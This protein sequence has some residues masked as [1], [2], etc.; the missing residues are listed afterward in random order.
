MGKIIMEGAKEIARDM[1]DAINVDSDG[2]W[3][4]VGK[5]FTSLPVIFV[6]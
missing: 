4:A 6:I 5:D 2:F 1:L 3:G